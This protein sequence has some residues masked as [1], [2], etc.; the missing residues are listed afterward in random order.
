MDGRVEKLSNFGA[1]VR[2]TDHIIGLMHISE[3]SHDHIKAPSTVCRIGDKLRVK[4]INIDHENG[5][6]GLSHKETYTDPI[7]DIVEGEDYEAV[8]DNLTDFGAF[9][10]LP[11]TAV[12][13]VHISEVTYAKFE[14]LSDVLRI[15]QKIRVK[16]LN[17]NIR[18]R[19][20]S[21][22]IKALEQ[23]PWEAVHERF[24][25]G[26]R[27]DVTVKELN[28]AGI[29]VVLGDKYDGFI[30]IGE[31]S[32]ERIDHPS[33]VHAVGDVVK[34]Q[35][36]NIDGPRRKIRL[37]IRQTLDRYA[38]EGTEY[39]R[40]TDE[41][42]RPTA[43]AM[44]LGDL[45]AKSGLMATP[46][47][48]KISS[49]AAEPPPDIAEPQPEIDVTPAQTE[50]SAEQS[51]PSLDLP[52]FTEDS[53]EQEVLDAGPVADDEAEG[54]DEDEEASPE[55]IAADSESMQPESDVE[56]ES[57]KSEAGE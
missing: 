8:V 16:V 11:N 47:E 40:V 50:E 49:E 3:M 41:D 17:V 45:L 23:D 36:I 27:I 14:K 29:V 57:P 30:P 25:V 18:D 13:L 51:E 31:I 34:A 5:R 26:E 52:G 46:I 33:K 2:I 24:A 7:L 55:E 53:N 21:L 35:I 4:I 15:G 43:V 39:V 12:G 19:R 38:E 9:V 37:S 20:V 44:T 6:V 28:N 10:R 56:P 32:H 22:S 42:R 1:F 54:K 48:E